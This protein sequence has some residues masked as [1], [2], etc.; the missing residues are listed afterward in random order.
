MIPSGSCAA[1][2]GVNM[3]HLY[4][5]EPEKADLVKK[6]AG[7]TFEFVEFLT[8]VHQDPSLVEKISGPTAA[9]HYSCHQRELGLTT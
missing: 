9:Y 1:M 3:E 6:L 4:S 8:Y 7:K 2:V 5:D